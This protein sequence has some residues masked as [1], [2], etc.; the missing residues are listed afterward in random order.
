MAIDEPDV[1]IMQPVISSRLGR[2]RRERANRLLSQTSV[3]SIP[4]FLSAARSDVGIAWSE[5]T[6][7]S[8]D[9]GPIKERL[10]RPNL[11]ESQTAILCRETSSITRLTF[12]SNKFGVL[13]PYCTSK[14]STPRNNRSAFRWRKVS[15]AI[16]PTRE[17]EF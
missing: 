9:V 11:L 7:C 3:T 4:D 10:R 2:K 13:K 8:E 1:S 5:M 17:N 16:G 6:P 12:D 14:P 15:S